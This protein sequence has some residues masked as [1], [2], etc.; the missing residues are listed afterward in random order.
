MLIA[1][2]S[3]GR[4]RGSVSRL[5]SSEG[6]VRGGGGGGG[7]YFLIIT[8]FFVIVCLCYFYLYIS[9]LDLYEGGLFV[10]EG[11]EVYSVS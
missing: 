9:L 10:G 7:S 11:E 5:R 8:L 1:P 6:V 4:P 3:R 2:G